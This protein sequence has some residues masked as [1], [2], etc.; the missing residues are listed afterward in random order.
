MSLT[1]YRAAPSRVTDLFTPRGANVSEPPEARL[2]VPPGGSIV[3]GFTWAPAKVVLWW[4]RFM[5][6]PQSLATTYSSI[7]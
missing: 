4:G 1:S 3:N 7:A 2:H 6:R 5:R